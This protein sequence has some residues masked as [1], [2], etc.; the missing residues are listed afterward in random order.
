[1]LSKIALLFTSLYSLTFAYGFASSSYDLAKKEA[2]PQTSVETPNQ[3]VITRLSFDDNGNISE[4]DFYTSQTTIN[5]GSFNLKTFYYF[6]EF[7]DL[8]FDDY[9]VRYNGSLI[10][11][12]NTQSSTIANWNGGVSDFNIDVAVKDMQFYYFSYRL[13]ITYSSPTYTYDV[14]PYFNYQLNNTSEFISVPITT[15]NGHF[16]SNYGSVQSGLVVNSGYVSNMFIAYL[17]G[18]N[19]GILDEYYNLG[20]LDG[21]SAGYTAGYLDG[22]TYGYSVGYNAGTQNGVSFMPLFGAIA[23]TPVL[24]IRNLFSFDLFGVSALAIFMSLLTALVVIHFIR[25]V[26]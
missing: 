10:G 4:L 7:D 12:E 6:N 17:F 26:I 22:E 14:L 5:N 21:Q 13:N 15:Y 24:I 25:K 8:I 19:G 16:N 20:Y 2:H 11:S 3:A 18:Y 9:E 23:D 1:M